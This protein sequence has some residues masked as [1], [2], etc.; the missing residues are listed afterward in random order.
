MLT[1]YSPGIMGPIGP[2]GP[3]G[4]ITGMG[5]PMLGTGPPGGPPGP[6]PGP[7]GLPAIHT[8]YSKIGLKHESSCT[9]YWHLFYTQQSSRTYVAA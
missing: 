2:I 3:P 8:I 9:H 5:P 6:G 1:L 7:P 4:P